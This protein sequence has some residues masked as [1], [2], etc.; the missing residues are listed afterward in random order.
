LRADTGADHKGRLSKLS[1]CPK[2]PSNLLNVWHIRQWSFA[3]YYRAHRGSG[4]HNGGSNNTI[5]RF[6]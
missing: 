4:V 6:T 2:T 1:T 5:S 3:H